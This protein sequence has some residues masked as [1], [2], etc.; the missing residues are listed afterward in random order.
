MIGVLVAIN[1]V[2]A[3]AHVAKNQFMARKPG[4]DQG[5]QPAIMLHSLSKRIAD[6]ADMVPLF[7]FKILS[8]GCASRSNHRK[9][10]KQRFHLH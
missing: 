1:F 4:V 8:R 5:F 3:V 10:Q 2:T 6:D 9:N 7:Q